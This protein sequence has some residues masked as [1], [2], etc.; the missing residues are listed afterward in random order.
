MQVM[1]SRQRHSTG[2]LI[3]LQKPSFHLSHCWSCYTAPIFSKIGTDNSKFI[4]SYFSRYS[5]NCRGTALP[6]NSAQIKLQSKFPELSA[7]FDCQCLALLHFILRRPPDSGK[8]QHRNVTWVRGQGMG[9]V[10]GRDLGDRE[11]PL[12]PLTHFRGRKTQKWSSNAYV[13]WEK[14]NWT[15]TPQAP[16]CKSAIPVFLLRARACV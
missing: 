12:L 1:N 9:V 14:T 13:A 11:Y 16:V 10:K 15:L 3:S 4:G 7:G 2:W 6:A 5:L 8:H